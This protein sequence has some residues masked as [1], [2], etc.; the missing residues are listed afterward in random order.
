M[1]AERS[2]DG[3]SIEEARTIR[4]TD[5]NWPDGRADM[6]LELFAAARELTIPGV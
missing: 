6:I 5:A 3:Q 2:V 1:N 4:E